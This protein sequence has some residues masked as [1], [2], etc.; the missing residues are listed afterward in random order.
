MAT[1]GRYT[2]AGSAQ[3]VEAGGAVAFNSSVDTRGLSCDGTTVTIAR[4]GDYVVSASVVVQAAAAGSV[5]FA[6]YRNGSAAAG[7]Q[8]LM[9][10]AASGD[11]ASGSASTVLTCPKCG[12]AMVDVR[13]LYAES[14]VS[15]VLTV[16][17][18]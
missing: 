18:V 17:M 16:E 11:Y 5:G 14:V 3:P 13:A 2:Y 8:A 7:A 15:A 10:A 6:L 1:I 9:T 12:Q 4:P